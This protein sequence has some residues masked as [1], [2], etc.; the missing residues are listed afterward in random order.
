MVL[1]HMCVTG[2]PLAAGFHNE[3]VVFLFVGKARL[4]EAANPSIGRFGAVPNLMLRK[5]TLIC[6]STNVLTWIIYSRVS[7]SRGGRHMRRAED[8]R[9]SFMGRK[10]FLIQEESL[11]I[12]T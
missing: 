9:L 8:I 10:L 1:T 2:S 12:L 4:R 3:K 7:L 5:R 6:I 11:P